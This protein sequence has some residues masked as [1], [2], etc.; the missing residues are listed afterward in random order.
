MSDYL[1]GPGPIA[2][3][4]R[5][6]G[7]EVPENSR[8]AVEHTLALGLGYLETDVHATAD[9]VVVLSHDPTVDRVTDGT[10]AVGEMDWDRLATLRDASGERLLR[11]DE[12][13]SDYPDLRVNIDAKDDAVV[14]PLVDTLRA[15]GALDRVC[16]ASFSDERLRRLRAELGPGVATSLGRRDTARLVAA[17]RLGA[18]VRRSVA[19]PAQGAVCVQVPPRY[20]GVPIVT[21]RFVATAHRHGLAVHVWTVDEPAE[22]VRLLDLGVDGLISDRPR[23]LREVLTARGAWH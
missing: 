12:L 18:R 17:A 7:R 2:L 19:G 22:M 14:G 11:L 16:L 6:G 4:H 8:A 20:R 9:G 23:V 13:L 3:A 21:R 10:G 5:G 15:A 1:S